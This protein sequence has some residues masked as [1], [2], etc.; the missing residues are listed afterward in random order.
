M[1]IFGDGNIKT[2]IYE[3]L[4]YIFRQHYD[5]EFY[6]SDVNEKLKFVQELLKVVATITEDVL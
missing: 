6:D 4:M 1:S 5:K 3:N 2:D